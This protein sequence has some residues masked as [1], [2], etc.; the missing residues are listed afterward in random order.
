MA[1][2]FCTKCGFV[3]ESFKGLTGCPSCGTTKSIPCDNK[4]QVN[5]NIN[6]HELRILCI[7]AERWVGTFKEYDQAQSGEVLRSIVKRLLKQLP[8]GTSLLLCDEVKELKKEYDVQT[9]I[10]DLGESNEKD[11]I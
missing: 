6:I 2:G 11:V 4:N 7:W 10:L 9:N 3:I 8:K 1:E 5:V